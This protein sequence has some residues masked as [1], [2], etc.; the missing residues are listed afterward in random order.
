MSNLPH[1]RAGGSRH[2][3]SAAT[4]P[5]PVSR[6]A[7]VHDLVDA[8]RE[9]QLADEVIG[10]ATNAKL[11][12]IVAQIRALQEQAREVLT[13]ARENAL[14][15]RAACNF[16]KKIGLVYHLYHRAEGDAYFSMLSPDDWN[17]R[18][19]HPYEGSYRLEPDMSWTRMD[20][21][22]AP[23]PARRFDVAALVGEA[24]EVV[25]SLPGRAP[26]SDP[27]DAAPPADQPADDLSDEP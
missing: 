4:S 7:P 5:Y 22:H 17:G 13:S 11:E 14:L 10:T 2:E 12:V 19:P 3:G 6:L 23:P 1:R 16:Q 8:A 24:P 18:A 21:G 27:R 20:T 26:A 25:A 15:H 9:I